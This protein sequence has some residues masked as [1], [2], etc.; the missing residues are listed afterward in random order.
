MLQRLVSFA[1]PTSWSPGAWRHG[2]L[3]GASCV[4]LMGAMWLVPL[5][6]VH[7]QTTVNYNFEDGVMRGTPTK[8][9][10][11][12][13]ILTETGNNFMRITG[14]TGDCQAIPSNLCPPRNRST[15]WFTSHFSSMPLITSANM[16]QTYSADIRFHDDTGTD[17]VV[18]ELFQDG[19][20]E[21]GY[22]TADG[23]GPVVIFW[24]KNGRVAGRA[25]Y[26]KGSQLAFNNFDLG[27]VRSGTWHNYKVVAVWS[28]DPSQGR[29]EV[30]FD[31]QLKLR[32]TGR[33]ANLDS[34]S[35]RIPALKLGLY[36]DYAVGRIDVDDVKAGPSTGSS[37]APSVALS[38]PTNVRLASGE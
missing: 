9:K 10:V 31:G 24:R 20:Q 26:V 6:S 7:A 14:S 16:R 17:G 37:P 21:G 34:T 27:T 11:P 19:P 12:P 18:F 3:L 38:A 4:A 30:Y 32:V 13:K 29:I 36:G 5:A 8:M 22:G 2:S 35:N 1:L 15:V 23:Q 28:H 25:N 33:D